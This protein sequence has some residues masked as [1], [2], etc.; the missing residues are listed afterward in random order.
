MKRIL[1]LTL[2][3][4]YFIEIAEE[5]KKWEY[6]KTTEYWKKRLTEPSPLYSGHSLHI[7][8]FDEVWF[9]NGY[10]K[11]KPFMRVEWKKLCLRPYEDDVHFAIGLGK[12]LEIRN[13]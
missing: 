5:R 2:K 3:L 13:S 4:K 11:D 7:K 9:R 12:V 8:K 1:H 10:T 6:R